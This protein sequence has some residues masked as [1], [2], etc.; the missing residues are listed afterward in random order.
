MH[1]RREEVRNRRKLAAEA[2]GAGGPAA[3]AAALADIDVYRSLRR[4]GFGTADAADRVAALLNLALAGEPPG[5][6]R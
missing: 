6:R 4:E 3:L 2:V 5:G 1:S